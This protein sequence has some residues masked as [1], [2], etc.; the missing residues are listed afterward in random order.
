[1]NYGTPPSSVLLAPLAKIIRAD[2]VGSSCKFCSHVPN[3]A[4]ATNG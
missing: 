1:L 4:S 2:G 3:L